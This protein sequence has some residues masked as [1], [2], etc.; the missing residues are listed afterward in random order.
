MAVAARC[1]C[2]NPPAYRPRLPLP[3]GGHTMKGTVEGCVRSIPVG[4][5]MAA[6]SPATDLWVT[7]V[8]VS[9][10]ACGNGVPLGE[11]EFTSTV[12]N[13]YSWVTR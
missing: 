9:S 7:D 13:P 10:S 1:I 8:I 4:R 6:G 5:A 3:A 11:L 2:R 12:P